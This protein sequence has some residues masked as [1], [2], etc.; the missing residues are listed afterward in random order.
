M[1]VNI[2]HE[3]CVGHARCYL[4]E[5]DYI[6]ADERGRGVVRDDAP[7]MPPEVAR[8]LVRAC[9]EFAITIQRD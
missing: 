7:D 9:P 2:D 5:P 1:N 4:L 6:T 3:L 8:K